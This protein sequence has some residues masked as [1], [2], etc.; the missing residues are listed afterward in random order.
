MSQSFL[1]NLVGFGLLGAILGGF[2]FPV[3]SVNGGN[4]VWW[5]LVGFGLDG[6]FAG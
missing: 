2:W 3:V 6:G 4:K 5:L 1:L